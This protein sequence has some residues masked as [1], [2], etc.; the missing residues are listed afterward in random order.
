M[1]R[2]DLVEKIAAKHELSK[3]EAA[4]IL[5]TVTDEIVATVKKNDPLT[6]VGFGTFKLQA[7]PAREGRNPFT[8]KTIKIPAKSVPKFVPGSAF[9]DAVN[10]KAKAKVECKGKKCK[11]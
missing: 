6:L 2:L 1:N 10:K 11:K 7:R 9:K 5:E 4:R 8:G 3:A